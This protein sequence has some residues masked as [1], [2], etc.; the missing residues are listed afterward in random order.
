LAEIDLIPSDY[1]LAQRRDR[2]LH[3]LARVAGALLVTGIAAAGSLAYAASRVHAELD[4]LTLAQRLS[5]Q[6]RTELEH[7]DAERVR[8]EQQLQRLEALRGGGDIGA[9]FRLIDRTLPTGELW[10]ERW[11]LLRTGEEGRP[12]GAAVATPA[13]T[14]AATPP[15]TAVAGRQMRIFGQARD[16]EALSRFVR[17]LYESPEVEDVHLE[18]TTLR[19]YTTTSVVAFELAVALK[20]AA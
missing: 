2:A 19:R 11:E 9:L 7:L 16:H 15:S 12:G 20:D 17:E 13:A 8:L 18:R 10:F 1:R 14:A 5:E 6:Q 3:T 4:E